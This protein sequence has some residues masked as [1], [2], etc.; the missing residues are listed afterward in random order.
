M[1]KDSKNKN[2]NVCINFFQ[3]LAAEQNNNNIYAYINYILQY[4]YCIP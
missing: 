2:Y 1:C 4:S 3:W